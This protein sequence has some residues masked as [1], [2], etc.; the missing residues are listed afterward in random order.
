[1]NPINN[2]TPISILNV[3]SLIDGKLGG[4]TAE[5][6][7][8]LSEQLALRSYDVRILAL[9]IG[10]AISIKNVDT[11]LIPAVSIR[12]LLPNP[13]YFLKIYKCIKDVDLIH[14]MGHWSIL[15]ILVFIFAKK[16]RKPYIFCPAGSLSIQ[17]RSK[18]LK[19]I[20]NLVIGNSIVNNAKF[21]IAITSDE[22][23]IFKK[24]GISSN[25]IKLIPNGIRESINPYSG[26]NIEHINLPD[27]YILYMGRIDFI[28]GPDILLESFLSIADKF[29]DVGLVYAGPDNGMQSELEKK[30]ASS[31]IKGRVHFLGYVSGPLKDFIFSKALFLVVPS[32]SEAMSIVA[33]EAGVHGKAALVT[34]ACGLHEVT[35]VSE[36]LEVEPNSCAIASGLRALLSD[37]RA[38]ILYSR[39]WNNHVIK[40]Y[41]WN[42]L[43]YLY[44]DLIT[45][46]LQNKKETS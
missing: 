25:K 41:A 3:N 15:N 14:M 20:Y 34:K 21:I 11:T 1:M 27:K 16:Q 32:R 10:G 5:R 8:R 26:V 35:K 12:Y 7:I 23:S 17:G 28:K 39:L 37:E 45:N 18:I 44:E 38:L 4:G 6:T 30:I 24:F 9:K 22:R 42:S 13:I 29:P 33:L 2:K 46:I 31:T 19:K 36:I 40:S 43:I